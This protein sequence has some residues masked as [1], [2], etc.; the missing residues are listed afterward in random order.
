MYHVKTN[1]NSLKQ[2]IFV[3]SEWVANYFTAFQLFSVFSA[4]EKEPLGV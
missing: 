4:K 1:V 3:Q 2:K